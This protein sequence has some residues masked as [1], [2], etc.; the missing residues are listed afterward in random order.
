MEIINRR[1]EPKTQFTSRYVGVIWH[2]TKKQWR[3]AISILGNK[4][5]LGYFATERQA[6]EAYTTRVNS[7][8]KKEMGFREDTDEYMQEQWMREREY[9]RER[10]QQPQTRTSFSRSQWYSKGRRVVATNAQAVKT[11]IVRSTGN[12]LY[13]FEES[14]TVER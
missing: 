12:T 6:A 2:S 4:R 7:K 11:I 9:Q 5:V 13:L 14:Q 1:K 8:R 10:Q 3:A